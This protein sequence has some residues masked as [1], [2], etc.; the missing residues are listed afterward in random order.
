MF[1]FLTKKL[2]VTIYLSTI[3]L[4]IIP[5][6][7]SNTTEKKLWVAAEY[8]RYFSQI[9]TK[10]GLIMLIIASLSRKIFENH[11]KNNKFKGFPNLSSGNPILGP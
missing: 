2:I 11:D 7:K 4:N 10:I 6:R 8:K 3:D 9:N 5:Y 1:F